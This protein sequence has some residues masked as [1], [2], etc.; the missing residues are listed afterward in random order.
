[1]SFLEDMAGREIG[2]LLSGSSNPLAA[3]V[4]Q[5]INNQ[6]GGL[7]GLVQQFHDKGLGGLVTSWV[8]TGQNL[9]ISADQLQHVLGS[10]QVKELA[11]K[12]GISPEAASSHLS[13]LLP[14]LID[15]LTPNGQLPQGSSPL[16]EGMSMLKNL[17]L[18]KTGTES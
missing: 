7:S 13:Q 10:E 2:S 3:S 6:P 11:A 4:M 8:G 12:A 5:M 17:G 15:K 18:G 9:P 16:E 1:M 14:M